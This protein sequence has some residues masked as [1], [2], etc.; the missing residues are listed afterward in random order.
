MACQYIYPRYRGRRCGQLKCN[1]HANAVKTQVDISTFV[2]C[3]K[4][5]GHNELLDCI[6]RS[7][8]CGLSHNSV[9]S[10]ITWIYDAQEMKK[11][12]CTLSIECAGRASNKSSIT[13][14]VVI[15]YNNLA[16]LQG[17]T[18][19]MRALMYVQRR[20]KAQRLHGPINEAKNTT[21]PFTLSPISEIPTNEVFAYRDTSG[22]VWAFSAKELA[23]YVTT[24]PENPYTREIINSRDILRLNTIVSSAALHT[25]SLDTCET[26]DQM[27]TYAIGF[28]DDFYL[29]NWYFTNISVKDLS[30][31]AKSVCNTTFSIKSHRDFAEFMINIAKS[32]PEVKFGR[33][34][35]L[36]THIAQHIAGL[37]ESLPDWVSS[38]AANVALT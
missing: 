37:Y 25:V 7:R 21:D 36:V 20:W 29:Q 27:F 3:N 17:N 18:R 26:I 4:N 2:G 13:E 11:L 5:V 6:L 14:Q 33:M 19:F 34:C 35:L 15:L 28:Y 32:P 16:Q 22:K 31:I 1:K 38:A 8:K 9:C 12:A 10:A 30:K 23:Y 24:T